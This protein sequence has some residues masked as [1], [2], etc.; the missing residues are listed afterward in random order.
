MAPP[1]SLARV[2]YLRLHA[3]DVPEAP[4]PWPAQRELTPPSEF[5]AVNVLRMRRCLPPPGKE[6]MQ[7][8]RRRRGSKIS[9][10]GSGDR[11]IKAIGY[12]SSG[13]PWTVYIRPIADALC[14]NL[15]LGA[16]EL[17]G[18]VITTRH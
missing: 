6:F 10:A 2:V 1:R 14:N 12:C 17:R 15:G 18:A 9:S 7:F 13:L 16:T 4:P 5:Y 3:G 8:D 11:V